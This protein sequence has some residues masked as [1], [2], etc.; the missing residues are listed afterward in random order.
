MNRL[1]LVAALARECGVSGSIVA[2]VGATGEALR[3]ASWIDTAWEAIQTKHDDW[4]FMRS[5]NVLGAGASFATINGQSSYPLGSGAGTCGVLSASFGKWDRESFR[6]YTTSVGTNDEMELDEIPFDVWRGLYMIGASRG[7]RTRPVAVAVGPND[8]VCL[9][10]PPNALYTITADYFVA[11]TAMSL[12]ADTPTGLPIQFH[13][14]IV[15]LAMT[16]YAGY[17][18]APEVMQRGQSGYDTLMKRLEA[19]RAP[20]ISFSGALV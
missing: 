11:P 5:S 17:E 8:S 14:M 16:Y 10:P 4:S 7:V 2:T 6:S 19:L 9:G 1:S 18:A 3:L 20:R 15:Y 13:M 12:D